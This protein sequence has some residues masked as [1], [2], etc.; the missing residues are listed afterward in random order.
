MDGQQI[1]AFGTPSLIA[2]N[3]W[4]R[5]KTLNIGIDVAALNNRLGGS[6]DW[7]QKD[8]IG[9][10]TS[11]VTLPAVLG[12][13]SPDTNN[14]D[15]RNRGFEIT[16]TWRDQVKVAGKPLSYSIFGNLSDYTGVV[17]KYS[18]PTGLISGWYVGK[19]MGEIWG[20]T[21]DHIMIDAAEAEAM[22][23]SQAQRLFGSNWSR[24]DMKYKDLDGDGAI[25]Y[26]NNTLEN[27]GDLSVIG[28]STPRY[29]FGFG[30]NVEWNGFD[31]SAL[32]QGVGKRDLWL[33]GVLAW[34][35][36]G[37]QWG[38]NV[39]QN[40]LD[41]W[42]EDGSNLDPYWPRLYLD[43]TGKNLQTQTKYLDNAAYCRFKNI[44]VGYTFHKG[45]LQKISIDKLRI[46]FSGENLFTISKIN[47][48]YEPEAPYSSVW[49]DAAYP[50]SKAVSV[51]INVTFK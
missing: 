29:N 32:L 13:G 33:S 9:L 39:W 12:A 1:G 41:C 11:G 21:T 34:G 47:E 4:E 20:Y 44:Q 48:N 40:T 46:Y 7:Y 50:L 18:N 15:I 26:G 49:G 45:L 37:G 2:Y 8:I 14:A 23:E 38:S 5:N 3:T 16:L 28:N 17:T 24:G 35:I 19:S 43:N 42:R 25:T 31:V 6:F 22:N 27:H 10:I 30:F 51:G 36:G